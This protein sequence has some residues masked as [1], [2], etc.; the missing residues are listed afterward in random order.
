MRERAIIFSAESVRAI[1][2]GRKTQ[3]RRVVKRPVMPCHFVPT[4]W[5]YMNP[6]TECCTCNPR[7]GLT[8]FACPGDR[9]WVRETWAVG[10][11][12]DSRPASELPP[13]PAW[14]S[15]GDVWIK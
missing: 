15:A 6:E 8:P 10:P 12:F 14:Y 1:L 7:R 9:L 11:D 4:G 13:C 3:T 5:A 2:D